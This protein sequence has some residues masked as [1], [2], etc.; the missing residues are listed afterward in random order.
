MIERI[1]C[2]AIYLDDGIVYSEQPLNIKTGLVICGRRHNNC[3]ATLKYLHPQWEG[4]IGK[5][6]RDHQG[7]VTNYNRYVGRREGFEIAFKAKQITSPN[8]E[9]PKDEEMRVLTSEDL[10]WG[11]DE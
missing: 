4:A 8:R 5:I 11:Y 3:Y 6:G 1:V 7:F 2:S 10:Y 9:Y